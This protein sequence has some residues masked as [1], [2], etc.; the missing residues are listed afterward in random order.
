VQC[1]VLLNRIQIDE[2]NMGSPLDNHGKD[3][4]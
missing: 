2:A 1:P 4:A 3:R